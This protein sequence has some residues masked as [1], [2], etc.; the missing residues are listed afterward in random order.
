MK[1]T[2]IVLII[3]LWLL[4]CVYVSK[5]QKDTSFTDSTKFIS[6]QDIQKYSDQ[7]KAKVSF[8]TFQDWLDVMNFIIVQSKK[9][10]ELKK[11][12]K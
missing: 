12:K 2:I 4:M 5:A 11:N 7:L 9:D 3:T 10:W 8:Q 1:K 6:L